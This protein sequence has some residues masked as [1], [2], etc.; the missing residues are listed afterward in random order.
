MRLMATIRQKGGF[1][2]IELLVVIAII[3]LLAALL[4]PVLSSAKENA[5]RTHCLNNVRQIGIAMRLYADENR[6]SFPIHN[7]WPSFGG[8]LG[9][10]TLYNS[11]VYDVTNRPLNIYV[12]NLEVFHCPRDKGDSCND[13]SFLWE[14]YG[15]SYFT[16]FN[17]DSFRFQH[18]TASGTWGSVRPMK[19]SQIT[20]ADTKMI[21]GDWPLHA[22]RDLADKRTQ[23]HNH[24]EKRAFTIAFGDGHAVFF[25]FPKTYGMADQYIAI[26]PNYLWW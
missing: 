24:G 21:V 10:S 20:R 16:Q 7:D 4:L 17:M 26:D 23:W 22:N 11:N 25:S 8:R 1:T 15:N 9:K 14:D 2:L 13:V 6:E 5:A 19:T 18:L 3:A 12:R